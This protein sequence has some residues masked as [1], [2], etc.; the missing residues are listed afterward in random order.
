MVARSPLSYPD[1]LRKSAWI[2]SIWLSLFMRSSKEWP[3]ADLALDSAIISSVS[4]YISYYT[5][6]I[7]YSS[8]FTFWVRPSI[9]AVLVS[10]VSILPS[11]SSIFYFSTRTVLYNSS[12]YFSVS[13][14]TLTTSPS[15]IEICLIFYSTT[16]NL[17]LCLSWPILRS[18]WTSSDLSLNW[19]WFSA[20]SFIIFSRLFSLS[21]C[22][23]N[24]PEL[25]SRASSMI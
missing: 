16:L 3:L 7:F 20:F 19:S 8:S 11:A 9:N 21:S 25:P 24:M 13:G 15:D 10:I 23:S 12:C 6:T 18:F 4:F 1:N 17:S 5:F 2:T 14:L 22:F